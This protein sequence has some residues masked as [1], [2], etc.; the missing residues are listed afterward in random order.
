MNIFIAFIA[1]ALRK[2][3]LAKFSL[4]RGEEE[5]YVTCLHSRLHRSLL[6]NT[7]PCYP[8][9]HADHLANACLTMDSEISIFAKPK[10]K[11]QL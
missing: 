7:M 6:G 9:S 10:P 8:S 3:Q 11:A 5:E 2:F 1:F 4:P